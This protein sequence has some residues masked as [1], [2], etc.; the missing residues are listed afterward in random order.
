MIDAPISGGVVG[1]EAGTLTIMVGGHEKAFERAQK[2]LKPLAKNIIH[3]GDPG[4]G[5]VAKICNN[6]I[7]GA[8]MIGV[9]ESFNL[10][11]KL[12]LSPEVFYDISSK[13]TG[14]C[15]AMNVNCPAPDVVG[16]APSSKDYQA[17]FTA[18]M[19][20]KDLKLG[21]RAAESVNAPSPMGAQATALYTLVNEHG[22]GDY[23][24][25]VIMKLL[26][27]LQ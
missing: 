14:Q 9:S 26:Q 11:Q 2:Y 24:F 3:A 18:K 7:L 15:W 23:D 27:G 1:A 16:T 20:L 19:M 13:A 21:Q 17:G 6:L 25:S 12:G 8:A 10:A 22:L 4:N 5:Q